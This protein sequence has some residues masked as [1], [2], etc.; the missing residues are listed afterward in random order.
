MHD[1]LQLWMP[2]VVTAVAVFIASS[3]IHM[4]FKWHNSD[5]RKLANEDAVRAAISAGSPAPGQY[6][7]PHCQD[8]KDLHGEEMQQKYRDGPIGFLTVRKNGPPSLGGSL[9]QWFVFNLA[10]AVIAAAIALQ[11]YGLHGEPHRAGHLVGMLS[12]LAY[13]GSSVQA[14]IWMGKPMGSVVKDMLDAFIYATVSA[15]VF[16]WL[17][18]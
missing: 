2:I 5:Y 17:W 12:L 11:T 9:L 3:L 7:L 8:M 14:G 15:L 18:P 6:I 16:M 4:V 1:L 13:G 10:L